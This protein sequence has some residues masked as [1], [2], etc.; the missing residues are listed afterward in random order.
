MRRQ[1]VRVFST[2]EI[3]DT[4][5]LSGSDQRTQSRGDIVETEPTTPMP[6]SQQHSGTR[7][8]DCKTASA[9]GYELWLIPHCVEDAAGN[10]DDAHDRMS[11]VRL[12]YSAGVKPARARV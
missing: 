1:Q 8:S 5:R 12:A 3:L 10:R 4:S 9:I 6:L 11:S 2:F 7:S